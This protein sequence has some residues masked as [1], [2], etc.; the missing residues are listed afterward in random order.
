MVTGT[1]RERGSGQLPDAGLLLVLGGWRW[2]IGCG[3]AHIEDKLTPQQ[4]CSSLCDAPAP[5]EDHGLRN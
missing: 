5:R 2:L 4:L 1:Q 3:E